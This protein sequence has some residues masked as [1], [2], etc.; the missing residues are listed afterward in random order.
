M[1]QLPGSLRSVFANT[2]A[3]HE[4]TSYRSLAR[5]VALRSGTKQG[6][7]KTARRTD[8][9]PVC[10]VWD[11]VVSVRMEK[12]L[13]AIYDELK[14]LSARYWDELPIEFP[15]VTQDSLQL[16]SVE[17]Y[18]RAHAIRC[19]ELR[20]EAE[21]DL[22]AA[23]VRSLA[24]LGGPEGLAR[25]LQLYG[26]HWQARDHSIGLLRKA[27]EDPE[28]GTLYMWSD[29]KEHGRATKQQQTKQHARNHVSQKTGGRRW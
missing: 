21:A 9:C 18:I 7:C 13:R 28:E 12:A 23:E 10:Q 26:L 27:V 15:F 5:Q 25:T 3:L 19:Q 24:S 20:P 4:A 14:M 1:M 17:K 16:V 22:H 8:I 2:P 29:F 6:I 11:V